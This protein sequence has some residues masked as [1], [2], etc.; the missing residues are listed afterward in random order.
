MTNYN[1]TTRAVESADGLSIHIAELGSENAEKTLLVMHGYGEHGGRYIGPLQPFV[2]AGYRVVI[3]DV[4]GHGKSGGRRGYVPVFHRYLADMDAVL[5]TLDTSNISLLAH[6][7]GG[8]ISARYLA[9]RATP[10][11]KIALTSPFFGLQIQA[12]KWK[13]GAAKLLAKVLPKVSLPNEIDPATVSHDPEVI[14]KYASDPL[15]HSV[16]NAR[17]FIEAQNAQARA[18]QD[19][20]KLKTPT[21]VLQAGD[22]RI[23][24]RAASQAWSDAA[25]DIVTYEEVAGAFHEVLFEIEGAQ[26]VERVLR[27]FEGE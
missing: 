20:P 15:N 9:T 6:S 8:L 18:L 2:E 17:W 10:F 14:A 19:A 11:Q 4:R 26:H 12:P 1:P 22:D 13:L 25:G 23:A 21:L 16:A 27:W 3:P 24:S 5:K 7:H